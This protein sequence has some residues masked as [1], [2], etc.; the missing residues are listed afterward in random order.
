LPSNP[1]AKVLAYVFERKA[2]MRV[3]LSNPDVPI[4][5]NHLERALW[6]I[7]SAEKIIYFAGVN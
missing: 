1:L 6:V 4:D 5:I 2:L 7:P 3:F